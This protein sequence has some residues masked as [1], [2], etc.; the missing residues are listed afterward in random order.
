M[1]IEYLEQNRSN[2]FALQATGSGNSNYVPVIMMPIYP[3][4]QCPFDMDYEIEKMKQTTTKPKKQAKSDRKA[5]DLDSK[6]DKDKKKQ[7][8]RGFVMQRL[9]N[10]DLLS[11]W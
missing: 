4:D 6:E 11:Q 9:T 8:K 7:K 5:Q 3:A 10:F 1:Q 2:Y